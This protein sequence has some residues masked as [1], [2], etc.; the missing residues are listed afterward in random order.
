MRRALIVVI[1][2][3]LCTAVVAQENEDKDLN[4]L[5]REGMKAL[6]DKDRAAYLQR[7]KTLDKLR[8]NHPVIMYHLAAA[9]A[10]HKNETEANTYL[11]RVIVFDANKKT[12]SDPAFDSI[13]ESAGFKEITR[14]ICKLHQP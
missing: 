10:L 5:Y 12:L 4:T 9:Y 8:S 14:D 6:R 13:K 7:F 1:C 3:I 11:K 2:F